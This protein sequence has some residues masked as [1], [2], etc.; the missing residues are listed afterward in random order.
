MKK[1]LDES[2]CL[3]CGLPL[4]GVVAAHTN[5]QM[6][7]S[8]I[9][10]RA[11]ALFLDN[12]KRSR[13]SN[14][15]TR[16]QRSVSQRGGFG[17][18]RVVS[19]GAHRNAAVAGAYERGWEPCDQPLLLGALALIESRDSTSECQ[20][21]RV[22]NDVNLRPVLKGG[23]GEQGGNTRPLSWRR[24]TRDTS[25]TI[26]NKD[27]MRNKTSLPSKTVDVIGIWLQKIIIT[28]KMGSGD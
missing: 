19:V 11:S 1:G 18:S 17:S 25:H 16:E 27:D 2:Y 3:R 23:G 20:V 9:T 21:K 12:L 26:L 5:P 10:I 4:R 22:A 24:N 14:Y 13:I 7:G 8:K 15:G 6:L 28:W